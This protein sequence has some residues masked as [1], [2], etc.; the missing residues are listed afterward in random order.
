MQC[1]VRKSSVLKKMLEKK[2]IL[3]VGGIHEL[4]TGEVS[5]HEFYHPD[6]LDF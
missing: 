4:N 6:L 1:I 3:L 2:Q 5:F